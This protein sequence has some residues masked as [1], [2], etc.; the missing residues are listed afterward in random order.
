MWVSQALNLTGCNASNTTL[1]AHIALHVTLKTHNKKML[2]CH[3]LHQL[4]FL[5]VKFWIKSKSTCFTN[6]E[7][8]NSTHSYLHSLL[9]PNMPLRWR[10][11]CLRASITSHLAE[12]LCRTR[13]GIDYRSLSVVQ[14]HFLHKVTSCLLDFQSLLGYQ[15]QSSPGGWWSPYNRSFVSWEHFVFW[16]ADDHNEFQF[17]G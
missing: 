17:F 12:P 11:R 10:L 5:S 3:I 4:T 6:R 8:S 7:N 1:I 14:F 13:N 2:L 15:T 9:M 16:G